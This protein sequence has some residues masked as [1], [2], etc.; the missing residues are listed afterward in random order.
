MAK[1][2]KHKRKGK[3]VTVSAAARIPA[4]VVIVVLMML[5]HYQQATGR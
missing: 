2:P 5:T 3:F 1:H 4:W